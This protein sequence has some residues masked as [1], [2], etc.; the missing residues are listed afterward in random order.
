MAILAISLWNLNFS[1]FASFVFHCFLYIVGLTSYSSFLQEISLR[2]TI[3]YVA[4][5][6]EE[7]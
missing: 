3:T 6:L 1:V 4:G 5:D 2:K 7:N